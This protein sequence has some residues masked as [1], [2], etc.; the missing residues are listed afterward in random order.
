MNNYIIAFI[1]CIFGVSASAACKVDVSKITTKTVGKLAVSKNECQRANA[2]SYKRLPRKTA[3]AL[4]QDKSVEVRLAIT[5]NSIA[6]PKLLA[7]LSVDKAEQIRVLVATNPKTFNKSL[8][9]LA[10][11]KS[12]A[13]RRALAGNPKVTI[14]AFNILIKDKDI[15]IQE[16]LIA[17][18]RLPSKFMIN[19]AKGKSIKHQKLIAKNPKASNKALTFL[20]EKYKL[21]EYDEDDEDEVHIVQILRS[22]ASNPN[23]QGRLLSELAFH[24]DK[25]V[26]DSAR[27][28][29]RFPTA[30]DPW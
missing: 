9:A 27:S 15:A 25:Q 19:Y 29:K 17:N 5:K 8:S 30:A 14:K 13:V 3:V 6:W 2:A 10:G 26:S 28:H 24:Q 22:I 4:A 23:S 18:P 7:L 16:A 21:L 12:V 11:D 1:L 20:V